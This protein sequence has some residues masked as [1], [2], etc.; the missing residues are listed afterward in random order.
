MAKLWKQSG[1]VFIIPGVIF[2]LIGLP[3]VLGYPAALGNYG[4]DNTTK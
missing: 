1:V 3:P 4:Q 2:I